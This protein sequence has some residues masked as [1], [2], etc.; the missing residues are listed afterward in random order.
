MFA[1]L[2]SSADPGRTLDSEANQRLGCYGRQV[3]ETIFLHYLLWCS[4]V[5]ECNRKQ[6][7]GILIKT[8]VLE[9]INKRFA[10]VGGCCEPKV[11]V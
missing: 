7:I 11:S 10:V 2:P 8:K 5:S 3:I 1:G 4:V 6:W 9:I